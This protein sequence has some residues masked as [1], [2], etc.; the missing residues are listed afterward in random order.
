M[1]RFIFSN[2]QGLADAELSARL[3][4][5]GQLLIENDV[6]VALLCEVMTSSLKLKES[7]L[8]KEPRFS[9][10]RPEGPVVFGEKVAKVLAQNEALR[11][12]NFNYTRSY[13]DE[14]YDSHEEGKQKGYGTL[15]KG[16]IET[17]LIEDAF[18]ALSTRAPLRWIT[19]DGMHV[20]ML[21][22][23]SNHSAAKK[24]LLSELLP[25]LRKTHP[26]TPWMIV[27]DLNCP[28]AKLLGM[29]VE[30]TA[31]VA[32]VSGPPRYLR[33]CPHPPH[34]LYPAYTL[35]PRSVEEDLRS[36]FEE[37]ETTR[38]TPAPGVLR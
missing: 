15:S 34:G 29:P 3:V 10:R 9:A 6:A 8:P 22:A 35:P 19:P 32:P 24:Q 23:I 26:D 27:G 31:R 18:R 37:G 20:Y 14:R 36:P 38:R 21:H 5:L 28:P 16:P 17:T 4:L 11:R 33:S 12:L 13:R 30:L 25:L 1:P 2:L 7:E